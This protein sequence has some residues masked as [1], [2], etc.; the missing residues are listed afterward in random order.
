MPVSNAMVRVRARVGAPSSLLV[1]G[2]TGP[3]PPDGNA[4]V[5]GLSIEAVGSTAEVQIGRQALTLIV[6]ALLSIAAFNV[7]TR[8][9]QK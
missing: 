7:W 6:L 9:F 3:I 4:A 2:E 1:R 5:A 8:E